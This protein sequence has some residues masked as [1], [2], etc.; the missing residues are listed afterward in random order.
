MR[1]RISAAFSA[2]VVAGLVAGC[3]DSYFEGPRLSQ[4]MGLQAAV[5][6]FGGVFFLDFEQRAAFLAVNRFIRIFRAA[7]CAKHKFNG[8]RTMNN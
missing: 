5:S 2:V 4:F 8:E 6:S 3:S 7:F 1:L